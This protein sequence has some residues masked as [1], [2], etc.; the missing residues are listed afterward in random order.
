MS[1]SIPQHL[2]YKSKKARQ[3]SA[4]LIL[5]RLQ[6]KVNDAGAPLVLVVGDLNAEADFEETYPTLTGNRYAGNSA[7]AEDGN[8]NPDTNDESEEEYDDQDE[9]RQLLPPASRTEVSRFRRRTKQSQAAHIDISSPTTKGPRRRLVHN[10]MGPHVSRGSP[11]SFLDTRHEVDAPA[12]ST[13]TDFTDPPADRVID[14]ILVAEEQNRFKTVSH[15]VYSNDDGGIR[16]SD[17]QLV[18]TEF[19]YNP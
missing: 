7:E 16:I 3:N 4:R 6:S 9:Y 2:D 15:K 10:R 13:F 19:S 14:Y 18:V 8:D 11:I 5:K 12:T 1:E 17:H